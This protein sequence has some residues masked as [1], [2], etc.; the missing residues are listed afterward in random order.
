M[1][2]DHLAHLKTNELTVSVAEAMGAWPHTAFVP[3]SETLCTC[4]SSGS[5]LQLFTRSWPSPSFRRGCRN[6]GKK[7]AVLELMRTDIYFFKGPGPFP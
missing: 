7:A 2:V 4:A 3:G 6:G 1:S 5:L